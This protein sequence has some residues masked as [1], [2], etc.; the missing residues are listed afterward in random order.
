[1]TNN[2]K[3]A[4]LPLGS[5]VTLTGGD[6]TILIIGRSQLQMNTKTLWDYVGCMH[7]EGYITDKYNIFFQQE[8]ISTIVH[9]G[10]EGPSEKHIVE[11]L[12]K[13]KNDMVN[14][15]PT[16]RVNKNAKK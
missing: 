15:Q 4:Y 5:V 9:K 16:K 12:S 10:Y 13:M 11:L 2:N 8:E 7:P 1:M 6:K 14:L 3:T